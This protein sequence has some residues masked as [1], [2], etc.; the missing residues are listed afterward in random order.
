MN[1]YVRGIGTLTILAA[2]LTFGAGCRAGVDDSG[3]VRRDSA[4]V[5]IIEN[6]APSEDDAIAL[7]VGEQPVL[8]IGRDTTDPNHQL[9]RAWF[10]TRLSSGTVVVANTGTSELRFFDST[11]RHLRTAGRRGEGPG[12]FTEISGLVRGAGDTLIVFD[13]EQ[14]RASIFAPEGDLIRSVKRTGPGG[15]PAFSGTLPGGLALTRRRNVGAV[16]PPLAPAVLAIPQVA[17]VYRMSLETGATDSVAAIDLPARSM[18]INSGVIMDAALE[19]GLLPTVIGADG[20]ILLGAGDRWEIREYSPAGRLSR[21]I[22]RA[23]AQLPI[24]PAE[25]SRYRELRLEGLSGVR[26]ERTAELIDLGVYPERMPA[27]SGI[28]ADRAGRLWVH[29]FRAPREPGPESWTIVG[30]DGAVLGSAVV[31]AGLAIREIGTDYLVAVRP[32]AQGVEH[33]LVLRLG[34]R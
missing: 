13:A 20:R 30:S 15:F 21:V 17:T 19:F 7:V 27:F 34:E 6:P 16:D 22:R 26:R 4:G 2:P 5:E 32:D 23:G 18:T 3:V 25:I 33:V 14:Q 1:L 11:G 9:H 12:E 24:G 31:P 8:E 10:A 28:V 29:D